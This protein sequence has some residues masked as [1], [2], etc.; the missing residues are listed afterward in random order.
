LASRNRHT[1]RVATTNKFFRLAHGAKKRDHEK[2]VLWRS[3]GAS[4][5]AFFVKWQWGIFGKKRGGKARYVCRW[6]G[7][8][9][10]ETYRKRAQDRI[11]GRE[12]NSVKGNFLQRTEPIG[13]DP[14]DQPREE[15]AKVGPDWGFK[16]V[17]MVLK[18]KLGKLRQMI[19]AGQLG[20]P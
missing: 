2:G 13:S 20:R 10:E 8:G 14:G 4:G 17:Q 12:G 5:E 1:E 3:R 11:G 16:D 19:G 18:R 6:A 7:L 15:D 9:R